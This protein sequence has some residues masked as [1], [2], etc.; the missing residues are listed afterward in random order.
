MK[1][2][3]KLVFFGTDDFSLPSLQVL[4]DNGWLVAAVVTKP[5][6]KKGRGQKITMPK[7]KQ[8]AL[9]H[10][11]EVLQ[12]LRVADINN[13]LGRFGASHGVLVS[14]GKI[15]PASTIKLFPGGIVNLHPSL[16]PKY[17]GPAAI[18]APIL[19]GDPKTGISLMLVSEKMDAGPVFAQKIIALTGR[20][21]KI[22]LANLLSREGAGFL[23]EKLPSIIGGSIAAT[24]QDESKASYTQLI[25]K[26]D[27][28]INWQ[29]PA[30]QIE[31][32]VRA[33][34]G[35]P[36][37]PAKI[38]GHGVIITKARVANSLEDGRLVVEATPGYI[39]VLELIAPSGRKISGADYLRGYG[40]NN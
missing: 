1:K 6:S 29:E 8:L 4:I 10:N 28:Y 7:V 16:L 17:R 27:G 36:K 18:E 31:R 25:K 35:Y 37:T 9:Q 11:I 38:H 5:D 22:S 20:E 30:V 21:D 12:P 33:Y 23:V 3:N 39:E 2:S 13:E 34:L 24:P 15:I 32:K 19:N 40:P 14:Y 26:T